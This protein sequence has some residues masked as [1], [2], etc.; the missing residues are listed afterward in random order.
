MQVDHE[1][2]A[3]RFVARVEEGPATLEYT[4]PRDGVIDL[5][6]THVPRGARGAG[7]GATL[8]RSALEHAREA[9]LRVIAS[10][11]FVHGWLGDHP[12]YAELMA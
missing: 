11:P 5:H 3:R 2:D 7:V 10:C 4:L 9:G 12:E 6:H 1:P 8:A